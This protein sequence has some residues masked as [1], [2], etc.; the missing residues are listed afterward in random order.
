MN[1]MTVKNLEHMNAAK[2]WCFDNGVTLKRMDAAWE[3]AKKNNNSPNFQNLVKHNKSWMFL[4]PHILK[5]II[6]R[7]SPSEKGL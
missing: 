2:A 3:N 6:D 1:P 5:Q 7:Y 4:A